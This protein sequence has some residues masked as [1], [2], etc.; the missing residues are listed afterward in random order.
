MSKIGKQEISNRLYDRGI[1]GITKKYQADYVVEEVL[2]IIYRGLLAGESINL[3]PIGILRT[4][5]K[6]ERNG[7]NP[8]TGEAVFIPAHRKVCFAQ[9]EKMKVSIEKVDKGESIDSLTY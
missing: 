6:K 2:N 7:R 1:A 3:P 9:G 8:K 5:M 4:K